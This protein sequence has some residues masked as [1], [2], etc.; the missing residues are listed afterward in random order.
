MWVGHAHA[1]SPSESEP[2]RSAWRW[3]APAQRP[4]VEASIHAGVTPPIYT[5]ND[6]IGWGQMWGFRVAFRPWAPI[7]VNFSYSLAQ[8]D[9]DASSIHTDFDSGKLVELPFRNEKVY[10]RYVGGGIRYYPFKTGN[11]EPY[12]GAHLLDMSYVGTANTEP[13]SRSTSGVG[14]D[15]NVGLEYWLTPWLRGGLMGVQHLAGLLSQA[16]SAVEVSNSSAGLTVVD[17]S[18][19]LLVSLGT[20]VRLW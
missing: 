13:C 9:W 10:G 3:G 8:Y 12:V 14:G 4:H 15:L 16:C 7:A 1:Q 5:Y 6:R 18:F 20:G 11:W 2:T 17:R 19:T